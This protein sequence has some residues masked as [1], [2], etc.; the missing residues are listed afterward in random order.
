MKIKNIVCGI[1]SVAALAFVCIQYDAYQ[2]QL[3]ESYALRLK[4]DIRDQQIS[5]MEDDLESAYGEFEF[6][7]GESAYG[8]ERDNQKIIQKELGGVIELRLDDGTRVD[9]VLD[10]PNKR[11]IEIDWDKKWAEGIGQATYYMMKLNDIDPESCYL[12]MVI[13]LAKGAD[14]GWEKYRDRVEFCKMRCWV[15]DA[16]TKT[17]LDKED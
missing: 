9:L 17:W 12:P 2:N 7:F 5:E 8:T 1:I 3:D 10:E 13:L 16:E 4:I 11:A 14:S 6:N 15:F